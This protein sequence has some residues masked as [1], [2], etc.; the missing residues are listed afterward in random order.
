M[1]KLI[2]PF[3]IIL[4]TSCAPKQEEV[5]QVQP[6]SSHSEPTTMASAKTTPTTYF[7]HEYL[8]EWD[9]VENK[10]NTIRVEF[11]IGTETCFDARYE[12]EENEQTVELAVIAGVK[13]NAPE[14]C[15]REA[16]TGSLSISLKQPLGKRKLIPMDKSK[17][18]L[19]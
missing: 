6:I 18:K 16:R 5:P 12:I 14:F 10:G 1:N 4:L 7:K 11:T 2:A 3:F 13:P 9:L 8:S 15:T 17:V 19:H